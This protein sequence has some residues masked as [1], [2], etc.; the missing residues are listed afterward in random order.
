MKKPRIRCHCGA[1]AV[2]R[3]ASL[4]HENP[5]YEEYLYVCSKYP[6]CDSYVGAHKR[7]RKPK[8]TLADKELRSK[9]IEAHKVF[10]QLWTSGLMEKWQ[11]Y[12][13]M[14]A[15]L[16]V[17]RDDAH[18][19]KLSPYMCDRL[20]DLC[21]Q[22]LQNQKQNRKGKEVTCTY[23]NKIDTKME[24]SYRLRSSFS[25]CDGVLKAIAE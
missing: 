5:R 3:P 21:N 24:R 7:S 10:N 2:L 6:A 15:K 11:A 12:K 18:I 25:N 22:I 20:I 4:V 8:G 14:Q 1:T 17:H 23:V 13:W 19:A 9:R 16:C